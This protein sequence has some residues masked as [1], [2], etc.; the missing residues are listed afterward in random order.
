VVSGYAGL[1]TRGS[2][3][4]L[5][6]VRWKG[7]LRAGR[8]RVWDASLADKV[9]VTRKAQIELCTTPAVRG[10]GGSKLCIYFSNLTR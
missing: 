7:A 6:L 1:S 9:G 5:G 4:A 3:V 2:A 10:V 8:N